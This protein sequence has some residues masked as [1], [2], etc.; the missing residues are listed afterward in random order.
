MG[1]TATYANNGHV[2]P[3]AYI[4]I[5][6]IWGSKEEGWNA[7]VAVYE[8]EGDEN[9]K[10]MVHVHAPYEDGGNP[11]KLLYAKVE[12]MP[13]ISIKESFKKELEKDVGKLESPGVTK[14]KDLTDFG[15]TEEEAIELQKVQP[16]KERKT[17]TKK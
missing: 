7:W 10:D 5:S 6:R 8:K 1:V 4:R 15:F 14:K 16:I 12:K 13:C 3:E 11:F 9:H 17:R 2:L